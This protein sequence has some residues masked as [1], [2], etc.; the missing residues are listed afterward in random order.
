MKNDDRLPILTFV[1]GEQHFALRI[2]DVVEVAAMVAL[3]AISGTQAAVLGAANRHG[4]VLPMLDMR[5][6]IG[7]SPLQVDDDTLFIVARRGTHLVGL[8]VDLIL[9]VEYANP[10]QIDRRATGHHVSGVVSDDRWLIQ[11][12]DVHA[13]LQTFLPESVMIEGET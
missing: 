2:E 10:R 1:L 7:L 11:L 12:L 5:Q 4:E 6:V 3:T 9:Q 8:V 13:L